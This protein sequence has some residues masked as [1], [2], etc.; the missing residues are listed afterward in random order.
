MLL[1]SAGLDGFDRPTEGS[2][3]IVQ[4]AERPDPRPLWVLVWGGID[5]LAQALHDEP[6]IAPELRVYF[7][8]GPNKK[9]SATAYDYIARAA[10]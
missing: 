4:C 3:W 7:I 5:D 9:W 6:A 1:D 8:G 10:P 2:A